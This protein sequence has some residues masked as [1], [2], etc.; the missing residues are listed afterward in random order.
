MAMP[1][2][3]TPSSDLLSYGGRAM[4]DIGLAGLFGGQLFGRVALHPAIT[5]VS[6]PRER[7]AVVN[8]AW[9]RYGV[10]N[11]VGLLAVTAGWIGARVGESKDRNLTSRER[12]LAHVKDALVATTFVAGAANAIEGIRFAAAAPNGAVPLSDG[13]H[14]APEA[15]DRQTKLKRRLNRLSVVAIG[16]ELGVVA[17]NAALAQSG[18]RQA[19]AKR[20]LRRGR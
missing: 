2:T 6:D 4:H 20:L 18:F 17:V 16:A 7:G 1:V 13:D 19:P 12:T 8:R 11:G 5:E 3:Y 10:I 9:R 15:S 14:A